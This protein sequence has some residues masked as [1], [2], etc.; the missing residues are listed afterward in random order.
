[1]PF[2]TE[3]IQLKYSTPHYYKMINTNYDIGEGLIAFFVHLLL[4]LPYITLITSR[5]III[6]I[7]STQQT[8]QR[9]L[10]YKH[11]SS[12]VRGKNA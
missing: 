5:T 6:P 8:P 4:P 3:N 10:G 2:Q 9:C 1:M 12:R 11:T 7:S